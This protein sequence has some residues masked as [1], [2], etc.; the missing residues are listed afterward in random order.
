MSGFGSAYHCGPASVDRATLEIVR[1]SR[2][3]QAR[4]LLGDDMSE[5]NC[6]LDVEAALPRWIRRGS[7][8]DHRL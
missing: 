2:I 1:V 3:T 5:W 7:A 4:C 8:V 6:H